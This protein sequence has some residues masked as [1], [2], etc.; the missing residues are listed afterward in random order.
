MTLIG[1]GRWA[2]RNRFGGEAG[3]GVPDRP[4]AFTNGYSMTP[5]PFTRIVVGYPPTEQGAYARALGVDLATACDSDLLL[6]SVVPAVWIEQ[7]AAQT[8]PAVV[9][10]GQ[11]ER[12]ASALRKAAEALAATPGIGHVERRLGASS[13][14]ARGLHD[15]AVPRHADLIVVG[16][17][18]HA[19]CMW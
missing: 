13:S 4:T 14:A 12:A 11:R 9:Y 8:G 17:S 3:P 19:R 2:G 16:S 7:I 6:A 10:S 15:T 5:T 1:L 18:H